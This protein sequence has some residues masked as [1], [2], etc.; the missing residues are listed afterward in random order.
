MTGVADGD[1]AMLKHF[2]SEE[3]QRQRNTVRTLLVFVVLLNIGVVVAFR[4]GVPWPILV[5][6]FGAALVAVAAVGWRAIQ[7]RRLL[8]QRLL[9]LMAAIEMDWG[10]LDQMNLS[11]SERVL[12]HHAFSQ[13]FADTE[14]ITVEHR[15]QRGM[16]EKGPAFGE[17]KHPFAKEAPRSDPADHEAAYTGIEGPLLKSEA[18]LEE[19]NATYAETAQRR[20]ENAERRDPDMIEAGVERLGDLVASGW[21]EKNQMDGA[22]SDLMKKKETDENHEHLL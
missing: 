17:G 19:A 18:L 5:V 3:T 8:K 9:T 14:Q 10:A 16:D 11:E 21:F 6:A 4:Q 1:E 12:L 15:R 2:F 22:V 7:G 13:Q 20:W